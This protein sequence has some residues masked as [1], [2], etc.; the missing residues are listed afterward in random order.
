[1]K[2]RYES[3]PGLHLP[4]GHLPPG[5]VKPAGCGLLVNLIQIPSANGRMPIRAEAPAQSG[6]GLHRLCAACNMSIESGIFRSE[7][8]ERNR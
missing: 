6:A 5:R 7:S 1:M 4:Q 2:P 3:L 8:K